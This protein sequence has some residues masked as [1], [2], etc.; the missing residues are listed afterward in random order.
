M[1]EKMQ[2]IVNGYQNHKDNR[3]LDDDLIAVI[4]DLKIMISIE[5]ID[6]MI[7]TQYAA[8]MIDRLDYYDQMYEH[9]IFNLAKFKHYM[10]NLIVNILNHTYKEVFGMLLSIYF[11]LFE[12][13]IKIF[14]V[15]FFFFLQYHQ[16]L[17]LVLLRI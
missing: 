14:C 3:T 4:F 2:L 16:Q 13:N 7:V 10:I 11:K 12:I 17:I 6:E 5:K 1:N 8:N 9:H 15:Y